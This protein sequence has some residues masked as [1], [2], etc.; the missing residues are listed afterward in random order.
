ML[1]L[2]A[3]P[4]SVEGQKRKSRPCGGMSALPRLADIHQAVSACPKSAV[5]RSPRPYCAPGYS[6]NP[7]F[8][9]PST[10]SF[11][12]DCPSRPI[13][14]DIVSGSSSSRRAAASRVSA[15]RPT[16]A[17]TDRRSLCD[18]ELAVRPV[19]GR[20][21]VGEDRDGYRSKMIRSR[22]EVRGIT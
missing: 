5:I 6:G 14:V 2:A 9:R 11:A 3:S 15:S 21:E 12:F 13:H 10:N 4:M 19:R 1:L 18:D 22:D 20:Q 7:A 8:R 17:N 16:W